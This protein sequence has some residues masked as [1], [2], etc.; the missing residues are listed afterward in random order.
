[1]MD[2]SEYGS[3]VTN[4]DQLTNLDVAGKVHSI[5]TCT[6]SEGSV[7]G[8]PFILDLSTSKE[9]SAEMVDLFEL[10]PIGLM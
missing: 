1:M 9:E 6:N 3:F 4:E 7:T 5:K 2:T 10:D 8:I